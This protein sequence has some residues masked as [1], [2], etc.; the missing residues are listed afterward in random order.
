MRKGPN[1]IL[2]KKLASTA[3]NPLVPVDL[4]IV[5]SNSVCI[6]LKVFGVPGPFGI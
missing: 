1:S 5:D 3:S 4:E 6:S 2:L